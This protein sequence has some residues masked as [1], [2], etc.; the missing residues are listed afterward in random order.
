M[1]VK[2]YSVRFDNMETQGKLNTLSQSLNVSENAVVKRATL[3]GLEIMERKYIDKAV[4]KTTAELLDEMNEKLTSGFKQILKNQD[5]M[6]FD[7]SVMSAILN[8]LHNIKAIELESE[9]GEV[10]AEDF[11]LGLYD[12]PPERFDDFLKEE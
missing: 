9:N 6:N 5:G 1:E 2:Q 7:I 10:S 8:S 11:K 12:D 4:E 3:I